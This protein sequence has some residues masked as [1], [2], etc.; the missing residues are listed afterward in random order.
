[1]DIPDS[2]VLIETSAFEH[3]WWLKI[4]NIG[5]GIKCIWDATF[6]RCANLNT[7]NINVEEL[8]NNDCDSRH[9]RNNRK[10]CFLGSGIEN[11]MRVLQKGDEQNL[12]VAHLT[13]LC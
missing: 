6:S 12:T 3:C 5:K 1:M 9:C 4:V 13:H 10:L 8:N 2:V 11:L 7:V